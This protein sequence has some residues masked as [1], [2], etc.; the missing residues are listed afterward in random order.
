MTIRRRH[1][2]ILAGLA[3]SLPATRSAPAT[4][5]GPSR[6]AFDPAQVR[7][8]A[9]ERAGRP[10]R[11][12]RHALPR[13]FDALDYDGYR[14]IRFR[15]D[16]A[17]WVDSNLGF[18]LQPHHR[19]FLFKDRVELFE[20]VDGHATA[21]R[22]H[23]SQFTFDA[24]APSEEIGDIGFAGFRLLPPLN[25]ADHFDELCSFLGASYFRALGRGH[26]YGISARGLA[27]RTAHPAGEEF[28]GFTAFWIERPAPGADRVVV[29]A[30]LESA[31]LTGA[32][33][34]TII[35]GA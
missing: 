6:V 11:P 10:H 34:F 26:V 21:L 1:L 20:V 8:L 33:R 14:G 35:P 3:V 27:I 15:G 7:A 12:P 25:R 2:A 18:R 28:P 31:S 30:L 4:L 29:H 17:L 9:V 19:G 23:P 13:Q 5:G 16:Q 32:Y 22:Y 24:A